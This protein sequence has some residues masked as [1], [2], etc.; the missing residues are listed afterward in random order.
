MSLVQ[1]YTT[2]SE[3]KGKREVKKIMNSF[4][5]HR[6]AVWLLFTEP[7]AHYYFLANY[8]FNCERRLRALVLANK[9]FLTYG[10]KPIFKDHL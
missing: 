3:E 1:L 7:F 6:P 8:M 10:L 5:K 9:P 4:F 2:F